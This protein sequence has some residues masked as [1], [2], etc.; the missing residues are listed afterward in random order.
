MGVSRSK[1]MD[2]KRRGVRRGMDECVVSFTRLMKWRKRGQRNTD[3]Q[4]E[5]ADMDG[6]IKE[7]NT[8]CLLPMYAAYLSGM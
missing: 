1:E 4:R 5:P 7:T 8:T 6:F 3:S 2:C